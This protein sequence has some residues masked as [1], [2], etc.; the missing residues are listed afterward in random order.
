MQSV[1]SQRAASALPPV[2]A[3]DQLIKGSPEQTLSSFEPGGRPVAADTRS[4]VVE[5]STAADP[6][7]ADDANRP[8]TVPRKVAARRNK[9]F[10][11]GGRIVTLGLRA[12]IIALVVATTVVRVLYSSLAFLRR[13]ETDRRKRPGESQYK[14]YFLRQIRTVR[15]RIRIQSGTIGAGMLVSMLQYATGYGITLYYSVGIFCPVCATVIPTACVCIPGPDPYE[16]TS[17]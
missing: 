16:G 12:C 17:S 4:Q 10:F 6:Q 7:T 11:Q 1:T 13:A 15:Y 5:L 8:S 9:C 2:V 3:R 14:R